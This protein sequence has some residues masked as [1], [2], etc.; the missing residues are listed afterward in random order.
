M[1]VYILNVLKK[2][3]KYVKNMV[4]VG[5]GVSILICFLLICKLYVCILNCYYW[6]KRF[7][8]ILFIMN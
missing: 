8:L 5:C 6:L 4:M 1:C 2:L 7:D 3:N